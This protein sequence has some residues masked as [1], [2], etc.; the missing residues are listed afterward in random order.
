MSPPLDVNIETVDVAR[1]VGSRRLR[2]VEADSFWCL[3]EMLQSIED[4]YTQGQ[5]GIHRRSYMLK[6]LMGHVDCGSLC[7]G[8]VSLCV[9][10]PPLDKLYEHV[11]RNDID[12]LQ[13]A[14]RWMNNLLMRE[15][16]LRATIR[17]WDTY[18]VGCCRF[19][20]VTPLVRARRILAVPR[21]HLRRLPEAVVEPAPEAEGVTGGCLRRRW[22]NDARL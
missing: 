4:N 1:E 16:P 9:D 21:L 22:R 10:T 7:G 15:L 13:F 8:G 6:H 3:L 20:G 19:T 11:L 18:L 17:L 12:F 5:P 14:Y 2:D